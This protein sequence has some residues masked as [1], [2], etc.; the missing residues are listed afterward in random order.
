[1]SL[2]QTKS[3][4]GFTL[5]EVMI[6]MTILG[7]LLAN[8]GLVSRAGTRAAQSGLFEQLIEDELEQGLDRVRLALMSSTAANLYPT[9]AAPLSQDY[10]EFSTSLGYENN[11]LVESEPERISWKAQGSGGQLVWEQ[12]FDQPSKRRVVWSNSVPMLQ[13]GEIANELDDNGN[14]LQDEPGIAF[15]VE[16]EASNQAQVYVHLTIEKTNPD[17]KQVPTARSINV[18]CRN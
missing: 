15:S 2:R 4:S 3:T 11:M 1:M 12:N 7:L 16:A 8:V 13:M 10:I 6:A 18:T 9:F 17:G 14:G 5:M